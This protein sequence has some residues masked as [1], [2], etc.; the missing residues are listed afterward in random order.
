MP[1]R[2]ALEDTMIKFKESKVAGR[3]MRQDDP[4][5]LA[6]STWTLVDKA[7]R[8]GNLDEARQ[9]I[10]YGRLEDKR[11]HD[12]LVVMANDLL[13]HLANTYGEEE[14]FKVFSGWALAKITR[15]DKQG[16]SPGSLDFL[17]WRVE[18]HRGHKSNLTI[19]EEPDR[20][21]VTYDPCG[22]GGRL[23]RTTEVGTT[24][25]PHPWSWGK[26]GVPYFCCHCCVEWQI[27]AT[28]LQGYPVKVVLIGEKPEDPCV[29]LFYKK[30]ELIPEKYFTRLGKTKDPSKFEV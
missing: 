29:H 13:T 5:D 4:A 8:A 18:A 26:A 11:M 23:R 30:P 17:H 19:T 27:L 2:R 7:L 12:G 15:E 1:H 22:S 6:I 20:Y 9:F 10:E 25:K 14:I 16:M 24:K 21:V 3:K 28:E